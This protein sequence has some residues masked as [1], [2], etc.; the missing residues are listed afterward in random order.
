MKKGHRKV[1][2]EEI[3]SK[4]RELKPKGWSDRAIATELKVKIGK[5]ARCRKQLQIKRGN[6]FP[7]HFTE[8]Y[9]DD[10]FT[11][12][13]SMVESGATG[14]EIAKCFGFTRQNASLVKMKLF[15]WSWET[16]KTKT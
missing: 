16:T 2:K 3:V 1:E 7:R 10:A 9:G 4:I 11:Q 14:E 5:I 6:L 12:L 13:Q 15:A 8:T